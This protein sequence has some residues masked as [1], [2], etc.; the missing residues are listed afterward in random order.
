[1]REY[2]F[3]LTRI[4]SYKDRIYECVLIRENMSQFSR[5]FYAVI[6]YLNQAVQKIHTPQISYKLTQASKL[7]LFMQIFLE[8]IRRIKRT[9]SY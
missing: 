6:L 2:R 3:S 7:S 4:L 8:T 5:I 9:I 1:M